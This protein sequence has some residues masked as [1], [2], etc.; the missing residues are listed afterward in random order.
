MS[1]FNEKIL[2]SGSVIKASEKKRRRDSR[3]LNTENLE[4]TLETEFGSQPST[5]R[6]YEIDL[7]HITDPVERAQAYKELI[8]QINT[9][10]ITERNEHLRE[11]TKNLEIIREQEVELEEIKNENLLLSEQLNN[12]KSLLNRDNT[13]LESL[14][15]NSSDTEAEEMDLKDIV[16]AI[17]MF[18]GDKKMLDGFINTCEIYTTLVNIEQ[19][20]NLIQ[21]I[22][23]KITGDALAKI[24]PID[25]L[26]TWENIKK[27][28]KEKILTTVSVEYA[29]E[30]LN[31]VSQKTQESIEEYGNR[32]KTK[33]RVLNEAIRKMTNEQAELRALRKLNEKQAISK[34]EQN[35]RS[36]NIKVLVSAAA[37]Q[38]LDECIA[39]AM[40]KELLEKN[41]NNVTCTICGL[42]NHR[43]E[44]C[45]KRKVNEEKRDRNH[46]NFRN[47]NTPRNP[48]N[49][50]NFNKFFN[51]RQ[52]NF[53]SQNNGNYQ[54]RPNFQNKNFNQ[55]NY[56][57]Q[58]TNRNNGNNPNYT[59]TATNL[60]NRN[61]NN[62]N[63]SNF[64]PQFQNNQNQRENSRNVRMM[65][66]KDEE[67]TSEYT[68]EDVI[69]EENPKN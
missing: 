58:Y 28:L 24:Q 36:N 69:N 48:Q 10:L 54:T 21:V 66:N 47:S 2:R 43:E 11:S 51:Y 65:H 9:F 60:N 32:I 33:L 35:L 40:E 59:R 22:K 50:N 41:K 63:N 61:G 38:T 53:Q 49:S 57:S 20:P 7:D 14:S 52:N 6:V 68:V 26:N 13:D 55:N 8:N 12:T 67:N 34:F 39:F 16:Q 64:K 29:Q 15:I 3:A 42:Y 31:N 19:K 30:D 27:K 44:N 56:N 4:S 1:D 37:K 5:S 17:P 25:G 45:R 23:A 18:S 62:H 46:N